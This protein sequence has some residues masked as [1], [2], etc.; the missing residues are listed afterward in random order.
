[1]VKFTILPVLFL[2]KDVAIFYTNSPFYLQYSGQK[3]NIKNVLDDDDN[4]VTEI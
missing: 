2:L 1:M 4:D 3:E